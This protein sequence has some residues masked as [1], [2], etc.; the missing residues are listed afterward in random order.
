MFQILYLALVF[1]FIYKIKRF[2]FHMNIIFYI[3]YI[4]NK[5]WPKYKILDTVPSINIH[6]IAKISTKDL[7]SIC[8]IS[9]E[10]ENQNSCSVFYFHSTTWPMIR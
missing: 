6:I 9:N 5:L 8:M 2:L 7:G 4:E 1:H 3:T 10:G